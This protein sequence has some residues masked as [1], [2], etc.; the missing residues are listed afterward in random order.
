MTLYFD[1]L[2]AI[3]K[4]DNIIEQSG[5]LSGAKD[6]GGLDSVL[7]FIQ[8]DYYYPTFEEKITHLVYG[9]AFNHPFLDGNKRSSITLGAF[10]LT[11]NGYDRHVVDK[12]I[13]EME[14]IVLITVIKKITK[15]EL[16]EIIALLIN[17]L[18]Y[19]ESLQLKIIKGLE[20][21]NDHFN[22]H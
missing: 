16:S 8:N 7:Q 21:Y 18:P 13:K 5:G 19:P 6:I 2:Q 12:F 9:I 22:D 11:I 10:F 4:H 15:N 17:E 3:E 14:N 20:Y 1:Y